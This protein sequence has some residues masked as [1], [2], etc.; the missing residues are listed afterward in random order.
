MK[1]VTN[2]VNSLNQTCPCD[3]GFQDVGISRCDEICGD[4][5][6]NEDPCDDGNQDSEDGCTS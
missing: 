1:R 3:T 4:S 2:F 6:A 5:I